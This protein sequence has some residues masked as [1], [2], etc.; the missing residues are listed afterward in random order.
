M[1]KKLLLVLV[2][3]LFGS[4]SSTY[5]TVDVDTVYKAS[6]EDTSI[7][8][9]DVRESDEYY[10]GHIKNA[11][12]IPVENIETIDLDKDKTIYVYCASGNRS[13]TATNKLIDMGYTSVYDMGGI[14]NYPYELEQ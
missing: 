9:L 11:I 4:S 14:D 2:I 7:I 5:Q 10:Q 1:M 13:K 6:L 12:N 3:F 8:I